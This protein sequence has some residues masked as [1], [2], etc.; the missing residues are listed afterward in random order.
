MGFITSHPTDWHNRSLLLVKR[1]SHSPG[2]WLKRGTKL[3]GANLLMVGTGATAAFSQLVTLCFVHP[4]GML[5]KMG[6]SAVQFI[7]WG[8]F[9]EKVQRSLP[10]LKDWKETARKLLLLSCGECLSIVATAASFVTPKVAQIGVKFHLANGLLQKQIPQQPS[11]KPPAPVVSKVVEKPK[12][13]IAK[14][15]ELLPKIGEKSVKRVQSEKV[16]IV[17]NPI[18]P[19]LKVAQDAKAMIV[20]LGNIAHERRSEVEKS[21]SAVINCDSIGFS[22][23]VAIHAENQAQEAIEAANEASKMV[24]TIQVAMKG[25]DLPAFRTLL[26]EALQIAFNAEKDADQAQNCARIVREI[27][28]KKIPALSIS[29]EKEPELPAAEQILQLADRVCKM[30][31][32]FLSAA[33]ENKQVAERACQAALQIHDN[34]TLLNLGMEANQAALKAAED[35]MDQLELV[36]LFEKTMELARKKMQLEQPDP[37]FIDPILSFME[38]FNLALDQAKLHAA[39]AVESQLKISAMLTRKSKRKSVKVVGFDRVLDQFKQERANRES[40]ASLSKVIKTKK[41]IVLAVDRIEGPMQ[42]AKPIFMSEPV[43]GENIPIAILP[44]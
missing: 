1:L 42:M 41:N 17:P 11:K 44:Q 39:E 6:I 24:E 25:T 35:V 18:E 4:A 36:P 2:P 12:E 26:H 33:L 16:E 31:D 14:V 32:Q 13:E 5:A 15:Q 40:N 30:A 34:E 29:I 22:K 3:C 38:R 27:S 8:Y 37:L 9:G 43:D 28:E 20:R 21:L 23:Q 10:T 7:T 19:L